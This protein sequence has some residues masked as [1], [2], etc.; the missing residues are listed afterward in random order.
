VLSQDRFEPVLDRVRNELLIPTGVRTLAP[1]DRRYQG[2]YGGNIVSR[3][4]AYHQGSA[5]PWLLG[6]YIDAYL[7][8]NGHGEGARTEARALLDQ[9]LNYLQGDGLGQLCEL[10]DG[11]RP[12]RAGGA[13]ASATSVAEILRAYAE[14][15]LAMQP[16]PQPVKTPSADPAKIA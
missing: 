14:G 8:V 10:F 9:C 13:I 11:D 5:F 12:H 16:T 6:A 4:R 1:T 15:V 3:D 7:R 2:H